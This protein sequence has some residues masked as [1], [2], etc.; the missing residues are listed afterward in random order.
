VIMKRYFKVWLHSMLADAQSSFA[1]RVGVVLFTMAKI[2]RFGFFIIFIILI[3]GRTRSVGGYNLWEI[4]FF[5]ATF[6]LVDIVP[7]MLFRS[8][9][10]FRG[11]VVSG[12]FDLFFLQPISSLFRAILGGSDILDIPMLFIAIGFIIYSGLHIPIF[13]VGTV[14]LYIFLVLNALLIAAAFHI[15][16]LSVGVVST[17]V[18]NTIMLYRDLTQMGRVPITIYTEGVSFL[19]T[20]VIPVGIMM[21]FPVQ[22]LLGTLSVQFILVSLLVGI[23]FFLLS[24]FTWKQGIRHY[25]SASS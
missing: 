23:V 5:Y 21:T 11:L 25:S 13:S 4:I 24:L 8:T 17:E 20:F 9:Y 15:F 2:L 18:D 10:R 22:A 3:F 7:Q 19:L 1:S 14:L 6:N 16:V 12:D